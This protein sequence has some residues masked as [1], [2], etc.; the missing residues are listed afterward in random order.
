MECFNEVEELNYILKG[1]M[2]YSI[3]C[4]KSIFS[5][6][7]NQYLDSIL[8]IQSAIDILLQNQKK[9]FRDIYL[10]QL[11]DNA[12]YFMAKAMIDID[13]S[14]NLKQL[15]NQVLIQGLR[16]II[17]MSDSDRLNFVNSHEA[18]GVLQTSDHKISFPVL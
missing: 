6:F 2:G 5:F 11:Y 7:T 14:M 18:T 8:C 15:N 12:K 9:T 10:T 4:L 1:R 17:Q 16:K 3:H 13:F